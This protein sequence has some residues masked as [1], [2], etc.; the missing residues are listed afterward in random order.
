MAQSL[1]GHN[2]HDLMENPEPTKQ[3]M[4]LCGGDDDTTKRRLTPDLASIH[5]FLKHDLGIDFAKLLKGREMQR[6]AI[7][8]IKRDVEKEEIKPVRQT[9]TVQHKPQ[10]IPSSWEEKLFQDL[11]LRMAKATS[12]DEETKMETFTITEVDTEEVTQCEDAET[13]TVSEVFKVEVPQH[14][15]KKTVTTWEERLRRELQLRK[16]KAAMG[17]ATEAKSTMAK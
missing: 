9:A 11:K 1:L 10:I 8:K 13:T 2:L 6:S 16:D 14:E 15:E 12:V 4:H 7:V 3:I 5:R 17:K